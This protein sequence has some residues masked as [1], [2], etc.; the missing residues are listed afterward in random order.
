M[1]VL[2]SCWYVYLA[3]G[4]GGRIDRRS[5]YTHCNANTAEDGRCDTWLRRERR[6]K[7]TVSVKKWSNKMRKR[8]RERDKERER[9]RE[10]YSSIWSPLPWSQQ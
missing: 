6:E 5:Y 10:G 4:S 8:E 7:E 9:E 1:C 2:V 3:M